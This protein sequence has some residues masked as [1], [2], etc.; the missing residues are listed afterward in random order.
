MRKVLARIID[1]RPLLLSLDS[2]YG[3]FVVAACFL[4]GLL[5][6]GLLYSFSV[7]FGHL[8]EAFGLSY[9]NTSLIFSLQSVT[10]YLGAAVFGFTIDRY[11]AR[12]LFGIGSLLII[13]GLF[14][15]SLFPTYLGLLIFYGLAVGFGFSIVMVISYVTPVLWFERRRGIATGTATAGAGIGMMLMPPLSRW[16]ISRIGWQRAYFALAIFVTGLLTVA[17]AIIADRPEQIG[18]DTSSEFVS[19]TDSASRVSARQQLDDLRSVAFSWPFAVF[20]LAFLGGYLTPLSMTVN[21]VEF[22][23][24]VGV[25]RG[26][27]VLALSAIGATNTI[28]KFVSGFLA[29][30]LDTTL[31]LAASTIAMGILTVP[32]ALVHEPTVVLAGSLAF[33]LGFGGL[34]ALMTPVM[35][36]MFGSQNLNGLFGVASISTAFAGALGPYLANVTFDAFGTYIPAFL[37]MSLISILSMGLFVL[38]RRLSD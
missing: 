13:A 19:T 28:G 24:S 8:V 9:A 34:G 35:I 10:M 18:A 17:T 4:G 32:I 15:T 25:D 11:D 20:F 23:Q 12:R 6:Y 2:Y 16:L 1:V 31:V 33:G 30:R 5:I 26:I 37:V 29:D 27:G 14:G 7:F 38:A 36:E 22:T 21:L 3:W